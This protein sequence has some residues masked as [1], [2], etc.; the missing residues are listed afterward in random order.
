MAAS[1]EPLITQSRKGGLMKSSLLSKTMLGMLILVS[2]LAL[3]T[4]PLGCEAA[5]PSPASQNPQYGGTIRI[6]QSAPIVCLGYPPAMAGVTDGYAADP[7]IET[8]FRYDEK[9]A[10]VPRLATGWK[11]NASAKNIIITLRKGVKFHD[12]S[13]R[14]ILARPRPRGKLDQ[15]PE[16]P[17]RG[18]RQ[19]RS[20]GPG[21]RQGELEAPGGAFPL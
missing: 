7:C 13:D 18:D 8:L 3:C 6:S 15:R 5:A 16:G 12:G 17:V 20:R 9:F 4:V 1:G 19:C 21:D 2:L 10:L 14:E 11:A